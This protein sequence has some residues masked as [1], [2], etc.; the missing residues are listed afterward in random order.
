MNSL[1][2]AHKG[3]ISEFFVCGFPGF[4][5]LYKYKVLCTQLLLY[6]FPKKSHSFCLNWHVGGLQKTH[7]IPLSCS[8]PSVPSG[9]RESL[10]N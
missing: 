10:I 6:F 8:V 1:Q 7:F 9:I 5:M 2:A 3:V 4:K